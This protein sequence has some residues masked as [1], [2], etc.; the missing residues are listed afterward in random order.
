MS[1]SISCHRTFKRSAAKL[2]KLRDTPCSIGSPF[3]STIVSFKPITV[4]YNLQVYYSNHTH[5]H[6]HY[7]RLSKTQSLVAPSLALAQCVFCLFSNVRSSG[8]CC[9]L[10]QCACKL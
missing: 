5:T 8:T 1:I 2:K 3:T 7:S 6:E 10:Q 4:R 9:V